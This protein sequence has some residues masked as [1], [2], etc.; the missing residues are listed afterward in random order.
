[1]LRAMAFRRFQVLGSVPPVLGDLPRLRNQLVASRERLA[2]E[3]AKASAHVDSLRSIM[4]DMSNELAQQQID[5]KRAAA[6]ILR[7][8]ARATG[9]VRAPLPPR[10]SVARLMVNA[11]RKRRGLEPYGDNE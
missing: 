7:A 9:E 1:M 2:R 3:E 6:F 10:G 4:D 8:H 11:D 5:P